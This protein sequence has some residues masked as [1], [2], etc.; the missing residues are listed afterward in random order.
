MAVVR[1]RLDAVQ[2]GHGDI[3]QQN[4]RGE[5]LHQFHGFHA[6][7]GFAHHVDVARLLQEGADTLPDRV[8]VVGDDDSYHGLVCIGRIAL[9]R[10]PRPG[11]DSSSIRPSNSSSR[12]RMPSM[13]MPARRSSGAKETKS[14]QG[15]RAQTVGKVAD[16]IHG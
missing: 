9:N 13:P 10:N 7:H 11:A 15:R 3:H 16:P 2:V 14:S 6:I 8:V 12:S 4:V 1:A 5:A